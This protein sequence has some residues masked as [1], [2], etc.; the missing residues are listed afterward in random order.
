M[1]SMQSESEMCFRFNQI[2][3]IMEHTVFLTIVGEGCWV[4]SRSITLPA[5]FC[6]PKTTSE[7]QQKLYYI[8][9]D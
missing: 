8:E 9:C 3:G 2:I 6:E 5:M 4:I 1:L 7:D